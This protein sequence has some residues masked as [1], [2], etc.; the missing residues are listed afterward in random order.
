MTI[1]FIMQGH[2]TSGNTMSFAILLMAM[3]PEVQEK[4]AAEVNQMFIEKQT[5][6]IELEDLKKL[7]Y[8]ERVINE[9]LRLY[10]AAPLIT[11]CAKADVDLSNL[12]M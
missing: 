1:R 2:E 9:S 12:L 8:V 7:E 10:P 11:R 3:Y 5:P 6:T 4:A